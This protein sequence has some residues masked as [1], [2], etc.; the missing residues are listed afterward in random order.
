MRLESLEVIRQR[1]LR[2]RA[3]R[4]SQSRQIE[5]KMVLELKEKLDLHLSQN[6]KFMLEVEP[7]VLG[8]FLNILSDKALSMY[9]YSQVDKNKFVFSHAS[10]IVF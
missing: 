9:D 1:S 7:R 4:T 2:K 5:Y 8:E 3:K 6:D 10:D